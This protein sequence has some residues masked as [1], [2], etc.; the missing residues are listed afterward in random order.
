[1]SAEQIHE[2]NRQI[3]V[4]KVKTRDEIVEEA[5]RYL[6]IDNIQR[7]EAKKKGV[8]MNFL[9]EGD[10]LFKNYAPVDLSMMP[11]IKAKL[12]NFTEEEK[13]EIRN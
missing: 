12:R 8:T 9:N 7:V 10:P 3:N 11:P 4:I 13:E 6:E 1:L 5:Y 2:A